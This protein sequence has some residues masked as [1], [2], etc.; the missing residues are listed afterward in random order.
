MKRTNKELQGSAESL[1]RENTLQSLAIR[2]LLHP[3]KNGIKLIRVGP[4]SCR[5]H[6]RLMLLDRPHGGLAVVDQI[7]PNQP[8]FNSV[9]YLE[10]Y[11]EVLRKSAVNSCSEERKISQAI[12]PAINKA[13]ADWRKPKKDE[14]LTLFPVGAGQ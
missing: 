3:P 1:S 9:F 7:I 10:A 6:I 11:L 13:I 12:L 14:Q 5:Y 4:H 2:E 8:P